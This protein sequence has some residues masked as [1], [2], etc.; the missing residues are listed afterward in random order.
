MSYSLWDLNFLGK[1]YIL[2]VMIDALISFKLGDFTWINK[3]QPN[4]QKGWELK[5]EIREMIANG[6]I[7]HL[8]LALDDS[9]VKT[10]GGLGG[11]E[12]NINSRATGFQLDYKSFPCYWDKATGGGGWIGYTDLLDKYFTKLD[13]GILYLKYDITRHPYYSAFKKA[14]ADAEWGEISIQYG[15]GVK[16][17][18][19]MD[20][21]LH[22]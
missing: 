3:E 1:Y 7:E 6:T 13:S 22:N 5:P 2:L 9:A 15:M 16:N 8:S 17:L 12:I 4:T 20:A 10:G 18:P 14:M 21:Y 19:I 11:I